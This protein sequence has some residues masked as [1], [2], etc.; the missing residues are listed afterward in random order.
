[1]ASEGSKVDQVPSTDGKVE[2]SPGSGEESLPPLTPL[3][4]A[5]Y[6]EVRD[7]NS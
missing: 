2:Q 7:I 3:E 1:M 6:N 5:K 4:Y